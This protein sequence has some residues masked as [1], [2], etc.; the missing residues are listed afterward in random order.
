[1][2][3]SDLEIREAIKEGNLTIGNFTDSSLQPASY[4]LRVGKY[5]L[6]SGKEKEIDL[7]KEGSFTIKAGQFALIISYE[8]I[9]LSNSLVG[10]IGMKS[11]Y[12]RKGLI[13]LAGLQIDPGWEGSLVLGMYNASP[14]SITL[15]YQ[16]SI[17]TVDF[18]RLS[19]PAS[20][21][22]LSSDEQK[23]GLIPKMD[24]D[25]LRTLESQTLSEMSESVRHLSENVGRLSN[26]TYNVLIPLIIGLYLAIF[27]AFFLIR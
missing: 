15:D 19:V 2:L 27:T 8:N 25:Y 12:I 14:R 7:E 26:M 10:H 17:C 3:L 22:F 9:K 20:K 24:K 23:A 13:L 6:I 21:G 4:D 1:M 11:Y 5:V 18:Y 16:G